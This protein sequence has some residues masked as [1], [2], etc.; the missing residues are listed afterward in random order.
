MKSKRICPICHKSRIIV[1]K[2]IVES[3]IMNETGILKAKLSSEEQ[4]CPEK[5]D[6][7]KC[8]CCSYEGSP[9]KFIV[10]D[11]GEKIQYYQEDPKIRCRYMQHKENECGCGASSFYY[12]FIDG[13]VYAVC[14]ICGVAIKQ[15]SAAES[16]ELLSKGI[17]R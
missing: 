3:W 8:A 16:R 4:Q 1:T 6:T 7:W 15:M 13:K 12:K 10:S 11:T 2:S 5:N 9:T 17:W 14:D